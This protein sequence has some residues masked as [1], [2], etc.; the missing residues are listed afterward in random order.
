MTTRGPLET[1]ERLIAAIN[2]GHDEEAD[3]LCDD[4]ITVTDPDGGVVSRRDAVHALLAKMVGLHAHLELTRPDV[5]GDSITGIMLIGNDYHRKVGVAPLELS[6]Q[7][8]VQE[9][10][11]LSF[12]GT[13]TEAALE[14]LRPLREARDSSG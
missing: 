14:K 12:G 2:A 3:L 8:V 4:A 9:G 13:F 10:K 7:A 11:I 6:W 5:R 1:V